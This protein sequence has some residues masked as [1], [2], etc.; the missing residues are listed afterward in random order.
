MSQPL[1]SPVAETA[2]DARS[3]I[4]CVSS[5]DLLR[6]QRL[7]D[8]TGGVGFKLVMWETPTTADRDSVRAWLAPRLAERGLRMIEV[9]LVR[10][11][12]RTD[13]QTRRSFNVWSELRHCL[14][15]AD[16]GDHRAVLVLSGF[17]EFIS[18]GERGRSDLLQ[19]FNVQRDILVRDYP[20]WWLL[21]IHPASRQQWYTVAPDFSDFVALWIESPMPPVEAIANRMQSLDRAHDRII[22]EDDQGLPDWPPELRSAHAAARSSRLDTALDA[23][24]SFR[25]ATTSPPRTD[26]ELAI[27]DLIEGDVLI[28][29]G[30][31]AQALRLW[32]DRV[33][34]A[35]QRLGL[36]REQCMVMDRIGDALDKCGNRTEAQRFIREALAIRGRLAQAEPD[37]ADYQR[38][39][40]VSYNRLGDLY[41]AQGQGDLAR[42]SYLKS[43][44]IFK[45]LAQDEPDRAD[46]QSDLSIVYSKL[47]DLFRRLGQGDLARES[48]LKALATTERLTRSNPNHE[49]YQRDL[50]FA[51]N[52]MGDQY[53]A[54]GQADLAHGTYLKS[55]AIA[56]RLAQTEPDQVDYQ[57]N[58]SVTYNRL[59]DLYYAQGQ[60]DLARESYLK[61]LAIFERLARAEPERA[62]HQREL[63]VT[64][65]RLGDLYYAQGQGD[66]A[67]ETYLKSLAIFKWLAQ[68]ERERADYQRDLSVS[69]IKVGDLYHALGQ[70]DFARDAFL[71]SLA[72]AEHLAQAEP[73][74]AEAQRDLVASLW[75]LGLIEDAGGEPH[76]RR[77]LEILLTLKQTERLRPMD[78][79][80]IGQLQELLGDRGKIGVRS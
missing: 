14:P 63:S 17:E 70:R 67:R 24:H 9:D 41:D 79:P 43:L 74:R 60:G 42:E 18:Q 36:A 8:R 6:F 12:G 80:Y 27:S 37:R 22:P 34:P 57:R 33:L 29:R 69:Y 20:C 1:A 15:P 38:D 16:V 78:E 46:Y 56:E 28:R 44:A 51:C 39:L 26:R 64:Y 65:N 13:G 68:D 5:S 23:I 73:C 59:G 7:L 75:R 52:M 66:L 2:A 30:R 62:D 19:Q 76:L 4:A 40:S 10:L 25:L 47:G 54:L 48:N 45:R 49:N 61:S 71:K 58:L 3:P 32:R 77:A 53:R 72:I 55:L 21:L 31:L 35:F 50:L 11:F